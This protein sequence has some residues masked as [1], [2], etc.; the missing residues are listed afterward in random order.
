MNC[1]VSAD[2]RVRVPPMNRIQV[3]CERWFRGSPA[4]HAAKGAVR[5]LTKNVALQWVTEGVRVNSIHPG[6]IATPIL[7]QSLGTDNRNGMTALTSMFTLGR[8]EDITAGAA[9]LASDDA[10]FVTSLDLYIDAGYMAR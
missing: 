2:Q 3:R 4:Y 5:T 10:S 1:R 6:F 7:E 9:Y 8:P